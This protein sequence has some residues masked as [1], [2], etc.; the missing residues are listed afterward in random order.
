[1]KNII[2]EISQ[3]EKNRILE[4]HRRAT[5]NQYL[6]EE[7]EPA[8]PQVTSAPPVKG[9]PLTGK[10]VVQLGQKTVNWG[11]TVKFTFSDI[12]NSGTGPITINKIIPRSASATVDTDLPLT[13]QPGETF[14]FTVEMEISKD[15]PLIRPDMNGVADFDMPVFVYTDGKKPT[16]QFNCRAT[17]FV[18]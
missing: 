14:S 2:S 13:L 9:G 5:S 7:D 10:L 16:Y 1:M 12:K 4:M 17:F 11:D 6:M 18:S 15:T 3:K 8:A